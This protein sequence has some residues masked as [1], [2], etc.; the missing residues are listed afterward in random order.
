MIKSFLQFINENHEDHDVSNELAEIVSLH[1]LGMIDDEQ[2]Y[3]DAIRILKS[4]GAIPSSEAKASAYY[5]DSEDKE[6]SKFA[7]EWTGP[8]GEMILELESNL[9]RS[10]YGET[11]ILLDTGISCKFVYSDTGEWDDASVEISVADQTFTEQDVFNSGVLDDD[12]DYEYRRTYSEVFGFQMETI[13]KLYGTL[14]I[15]SIVKRVI[16]N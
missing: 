1:S 14:A 8:N 7:K 10:G 4:L 3:P 5:N 6:V 13:C 15:D 12:E 11:K 16:P 9:N 2:Y